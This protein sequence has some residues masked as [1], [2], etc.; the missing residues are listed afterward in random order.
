MSFPDFVSDVY[1]RLK[2]H[3]CGGVYQLMTPVLQLQDP[4]LIK[5]VTVKD[6]EHFLDH[7]V[8]ISE[9]AEPIFGKAL[10]NLRGEKLAACTV[11]L[12][13]LNRNKTQW[14][15]WPV[16]TINISRYSNHSAQ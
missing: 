1:N 13:P 3:K 16:N 4:E 15:N 2:G 10:L 14:P 9:D 11:L 12:L 8:T 7:Q 6:S 5:M